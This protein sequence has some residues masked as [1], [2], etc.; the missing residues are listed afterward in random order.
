MP[1]T[2]KKVDGYKVSTPHGTKAKSTS[3]KKAMGQKRLL[4]GIEHGWKPSGK[5][6]RPGASKKAI[7]T[8]VMK[9]RAQ[10]KKA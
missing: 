10:K 4:Q 3:L 7:R 5:P 1:V 6:K 8:M 2:I 9:Q